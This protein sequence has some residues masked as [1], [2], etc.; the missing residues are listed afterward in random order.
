MSGGPGGGRSRAG[1]AGMALALV[2]VSL[3][4]V[5]VGV[6]VLWSQADGMRLLSQR[7]LAAEQ[8]RLLAQ[9]G[10]AH[11]LHKLER[12]RGFLEERLR[13]TPGVTLDLGGAEPAWLAECAGKLS[14]VGGTGE[15][16]LVGLKLAR[17][18]STSGTV[19]LE[20]GMEAEAVVRIGGEAR[21]ERA[22]GEYRLY[23][24]GEPGPEPGRAGGG[25]A[26]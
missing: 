5:A 20:V 10:L 26:P 18:E 19:V 22:S 9:S 8:A 14:L 6:G 2:L 12:T 15:W 16:R 4:L 3:G 25:E 23:P 11:G 17:R 1:R 7:T 24:G 21:V 13:A